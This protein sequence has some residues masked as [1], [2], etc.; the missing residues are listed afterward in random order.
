ML[1]FNNTLSSKLTHNYISEHTGIDSDII[2]KI[3]H[4]LC[5]T[6][7]KLLS[8]TGKNN[9]ISEDDLFSINTIFKEKNRMIKLLCPNL[10]ST[11][12]KDNLTIDRNHILDAVIVR[13]M[14]SRKMIEHNELVS[15]VITQIHMFKAD[16]KSIKK[17]IE[18]LIERDFLERDSNKS[19]KYVA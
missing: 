9:S 17:R 4:S 19:Y 3:L 10:D 13:I 8:K 11:K 18:S 16:S 7:Y 12:K 5:C 2:N 1:L 6:K 15:I 14:K